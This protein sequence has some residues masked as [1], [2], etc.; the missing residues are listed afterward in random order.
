MIMKIIYKF[1]NIKEKHPVIQ[2]LMKRYK[3]I[4][5]K[6]KKKMIKNKKKIKTILR[7]KIIFKEKNNSRIFQF[8]FF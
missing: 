7:E 1:L 5:K 6:I 8:G 4:R 2:I 3:E